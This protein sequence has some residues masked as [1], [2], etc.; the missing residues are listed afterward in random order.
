LHP[1]SIGDICHSIVVA[2]GVV[3]VVADRG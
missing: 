3:V 1:S 2:A